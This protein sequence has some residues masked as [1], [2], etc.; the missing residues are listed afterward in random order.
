MVPDN[1][2]FARDHVRTF[3]ARSERVRDSRPCIRPGTN[4][5]NFPS[6]AVNSVAFPPTMLTDL[7]YSIAVHESVHALV[8]LSCGLQIRCRAYQ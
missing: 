2:Q 3:A 4:S 8:G 1:R 7:R 6:T 5:K